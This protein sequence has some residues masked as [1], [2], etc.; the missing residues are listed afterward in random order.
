VKK[1]FLVFLVLL[2][3]MSGLSAAPPGDGRA[4][5]TPQTPHADSA[6]SIGAPGVWMPLLPGGGF[7]MAQAVELICQWSDQYRQGLLTQDEFKVLVAG[8]IAIAARDYSAISRLKTDTNGMR[9]LAEET[10]I[11]VDRRFMYRELELGIRGPT[12]L[13]PAD[14]PRL[15]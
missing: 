6:A 9:S 14:F 5:I 4:D 1:L 11:K 8:R 12:S 15:C 10:R 3:G 7:D 13:A 2:V